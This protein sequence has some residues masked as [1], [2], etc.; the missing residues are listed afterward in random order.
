MKKCKCKKDRK[1]RGS[2]KTNK[3][4]KSQCNPNPF[5]D[6]VIPP[7]A[8]YLENENILVLDGELIYRNAN[9]IYTFITT[10]ASNN[11]PTGSL[12]EALET[13]VEISITTF[14]IG[15]FINQVQMGVI[16]YDK[17]KPIHPDEKI[18]LLIHE[19]LQNI[20]EENNEE[21]QSDAE[22]NE[23]PKESQKDEMGEKSDKSE[24]D[25]ESQS[26]NAA[27]F[28]YMLTFVIS[29]GNAI[30]T[31][32]NYQINIT[33]LNYTIL[34]ALNRLEGDPGLYF[35]NNNYATPIPVNLYLAGL[36]IKFPIDKNCFG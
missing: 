18:D 31:F 33:E 16:K 34:L 19:C 7:C 22:M 27:E 20:C 9:K 29:N 12:G 11:G 5:A 3:Q 10:S 26:K 15:L 28:N 13:N 36:N 1:C 6:A 24:G 23:K 25:N 8:E 2:K 35:P 30:A 17:T 21:N 4:R 32:V 14:I